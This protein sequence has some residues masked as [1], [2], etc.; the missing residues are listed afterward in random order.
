MRQS[1]AEHQASVTVH[2]P[3]DE[4][5]RAG[6]SPDAVGGEFRMKRQALHAA[7]I[8]FVH[9]V[10]LKPMTLSAPLPPDIGTLL[11]ILRRGVGSPDRQ[12]PV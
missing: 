8:T 7:E 4:P 6:L 1:N 3:A 2:P 10:Q 5:P 12:T 11:A 9:P